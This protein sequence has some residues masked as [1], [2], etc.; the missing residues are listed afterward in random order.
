M[1]YTTHAP[2]VS[3]T[4]RNV[5]ILEI[6][7]EVAIVAL[8]STT[9]SIELTADVLVIYSLMCYVAVRVTPLPRVC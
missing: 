8:V 6:L 1:E 3:R 5:L 2:D 4:M 9:Q 7:L